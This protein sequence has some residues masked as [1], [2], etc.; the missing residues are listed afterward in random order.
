VCFPGCARTKQTSQLRPCHTYI[1]NRRTRC[2]IDNVKRLSKKLPAYQTPLQNK[3]VSKAN[4]SRMLLRYSITYYYDLISLSVSDAIKRIAVYVTNSTRLPYLDVRRTCI[5]MD[6]TPDGWFY[7]RST[8]ACYKSH[9]LYTT[10]L[11]YLPPARMEISDVV[12]LKWCI[13]NQW[14]DLNHAVHCK[15]TVVGVVTPASIWASSAGVEEDI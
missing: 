1:T 12:E 11:K 14:A 2:T 6:S 5:S 9:Y 8:S 4:K 7:S 15:C 13:M 10:C 3:K